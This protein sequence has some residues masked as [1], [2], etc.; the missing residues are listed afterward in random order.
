[1]TE[2]FDYTDHVL[3]GQY[4]IM[5]SVMGH[6]NASDTASFLWALEIKP[7]KTMWK[8]YLDPMRDLHMIMDWIEQQKVDGVRLLLIGSDVRR[9]VNR[10]ESPWDE[11]WKREYPIMLWVMAVPSDGLSPL[12]RLKRRLDSGIE[13]VPNELP[14]DVSEVQNILDTLGVHAVKFVAPRMDTFPGRDK[15]KSW[16]EY[17][18]TDDIKLMFYR[19]M[20][21]LD[22]PLTVSTDYLGHITEAERRDRN[23]FLIERKPIRSIHLCSTYSYDPN[24]RVVSQ[25]S[26][27]TPGA[28]Y[29]ENTLNIK[30]NIEDP[31]WITED[32]YK[33]MARVRRNLTIPLP[34]TLI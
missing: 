34:D 3:F 26:G 23:M 22:S 25:I 16:V 2:R 33:G 15:S 1:M 11:S 13:I 5:T 6:L 27:M 32:T 31:I 9:W 17:N 24:N 14:P 4:P 30:I 18:S 29:D 7:T 19:E 10:I 8:R 12:E 21:S 28:T 20:A